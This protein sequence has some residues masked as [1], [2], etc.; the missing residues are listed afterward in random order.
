M[1]E[2][3]VEKICILSIIIWL[4]LENKMAQNCINV[5]NTSGTVVR[6]DKWFK[7]CYPI[8]EFF[9]DFATKWAHLSRSHQRPIVD[10]SLI[11]RRSKQNLFFAFC[12]SKIRTHFLLSF[13]LLLSACCQHTH[14]WS[15]GTRDNEVSNF[16][17]TQYPS[18]VCRLRRTI[19]IY[20]M[21]ES[22][23]RFVLRSFFL[24]V[25][26][27]LNGRRQ[28]R[29]GSTVHHYYWSQ[30]QFKSNCIFQFASE[31]MM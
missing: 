12:F 16:N 2:L 5:R 10:S 13:F 30:F 15:S 1:L 6:Q 31:I 22:I 27:F 4:K 25:F 20:K 24:F 21:F 26:F 29:F 19:Y 14:V 11:N 28:G 9:F 18:N 7:T 23:F 17:E 3:V 8:I